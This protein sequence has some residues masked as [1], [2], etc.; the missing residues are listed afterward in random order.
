MGCRERTAAD[1]RCLLSRSRHLGAI[2]R[3]LGCGVD[4]TWGE[5]HLS[6]ECVRLISPTTLR[7]Q[8]EPV[9]VC[10]QSVGGWPSRHPTARAGPIND[11]HATRSQDV[12]QS[13]TSSHAYC[14]MHAPGRRIKR[15]G[16]R[17]VGLNITLVIWA[18]ISIWKSWRALQPIVLVDVGDHFKSD[19]KRRLIQ[20]FRAAISVRITFK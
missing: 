2:V 3:R 13:C 15:T 9:A 7:F 6:G 10:D 8:H 12:C 1:V 16:A 14:P 17:V 18:V 11:C 19:F 5:S 20:G 4:S